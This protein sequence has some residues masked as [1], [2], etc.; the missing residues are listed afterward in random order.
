M[1]AAL[2]HQRIIVDLGAHWGAAGAPHRPIA[3]PLSGVVRYALRASGGLGG[4]RLIRIIDCA[5]MAVAAP[6]V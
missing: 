5:M 6:I 3:S 2:R 4:G 1:L